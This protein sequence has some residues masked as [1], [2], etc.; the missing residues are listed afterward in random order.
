MRLVAERAELFEARLEFFSAGG[1]GRGDDGDAV[2]RLKSAGLAHASG[3]T[4]HF[5]G[6]RLVFIAAEHRAQLLIAERFRTP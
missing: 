5:G 2:A 4:R 6:D 1:T 3:E